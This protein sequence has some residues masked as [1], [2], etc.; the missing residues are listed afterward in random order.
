LSYNGKIKPLRDTTG[1][2][3]VPA[4]VEYRVPDGVRTERKINEKEAEH[5]ASLVCACVENE[6]YKNKTIGIISMLGEQQAYEI[7]KLLQLH[8]DPREYEKR[9]IQCGTSRQFQGDERDIVFISIVEGPKENGGPVTLV[10]EDGRNDMY[11]KRYN[12][13]ASRAK[14]QM[15]V[16]HSLNPEIDLKPDDIRL[17]LIKH[18]MNPRINK[19]NSK[20]EHAE[21]DFERSVMQIL[22]NKGYKVIP[23]WN[24]GAYRI[25][26]VVEDGK[27]RIALECDG[28]RYHTLDELPNDLRRQA[29]L[30][31][32]GWRFI[33]IRG[34]VF[35]RNSDE[36]MNWLY[37]ELE[38]YNIKPNFNAQ[39][40]NNDLTND[41][42][43][44]LLEKIKRRAYEIR[45]E[46]NKEKGNSIYELSESI[47]NNEIYIMNNV[48]S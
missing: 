33:R 15:W 5:I 36:T 41:V 32:L 25:D 39:E 22:L 28:E 19:F 27:N 21:S 45:S 3:T 4:V 48:I 24:V 17:K 30:E 10:S 38:N 13:A 43:D 46:W 47:K 29:I 11:R 9:K 18:A 2:T 35:Y 16:V 7:D 8:L 20:L 14:D 1:V 34:S 26:M 31:R 42:S 37:S 23:Q 12:V 44:E 6:N 40:N